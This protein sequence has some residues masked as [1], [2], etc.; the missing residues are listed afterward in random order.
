MPNNFCRK[1]QFKRF[2]IFRIFIF[3]I[4]SHNKH[5]IC[6]RFNIHKLFFVAVSDTYWQLFNH[7]RRLISINIMQHIYVTNYIYSKESKVLGMT[8]NHNRETR[9]VP[10][11]QYTRTNTFGWKTSIHVWLQAMFGYCF[12]VNIK[13]QDKCIWPITSWLKNRKSDTV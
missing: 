5:L 6:T 1:R 13:Q 12:D 11:L 2:Q 8:Y 4:N 3:N 9:C 7:C 10:D